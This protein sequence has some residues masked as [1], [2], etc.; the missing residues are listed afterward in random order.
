MHIF[1]NTPQPGGWG[2]SCMEFSGAIIAI[3]AGEDWFPISHRVRLD[4]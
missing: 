2:D 3:L 1:Q 4:P